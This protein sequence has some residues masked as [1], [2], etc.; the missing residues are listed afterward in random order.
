[1][2][3]TAQNSK[4]LKWPFLEVLHYPTTSVG[5]EILIIYQITSD[6]F[7]TLKQRKKR[8]FGMY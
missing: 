3:K 8:I 2:A 6:G 7:E 4:T 1:M 5:H